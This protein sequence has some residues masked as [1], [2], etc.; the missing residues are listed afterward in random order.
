MTESLEELWGRLSLTEEQQDEVVVEKDWIEDVTAV[1]NKC[2]LGKLLLRR[3]VNIEAM[4]NVFLKIWRLNHGLTIREVGERQFL[5]Y[6]ENELEKDRV[7]QKQPWFFNK[8]L[9]V[10][11]EF[12]GHTQPDNVNMKWCIFN[13]QIHGLPLDLMNE[14]IGVVLGE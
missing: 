5:F 9:I 14:K 3:A 11:N 6:F 7:F 13:V 12:D 8:S 4:R 1:G 10:L 2:L